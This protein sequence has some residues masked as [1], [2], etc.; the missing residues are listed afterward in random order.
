MKIVADQHIPFLRGVLEP[1]GVV[2]YLPG[3]KIRRRDARDADGLLI[4][5]RTRCDRALLEG[6]AVRFIGSATIGFDH[7][8][9]EYCD[10]HGIQWCHAPGCNAKSV[11]QYVGS[12]LAYLSRKH[13]LEWKSL[14]MGIIGVGNVGS[15]VERLA[16]VLDM[17]VLLNDP[18]RARREGPMAFVS[19][20]TVAREADIITVHTPLDREGPDR[21][22]HLCDEHFFARVKRSPFLIN[23][24]RGEVVDTEALKDA[25]SRKRIRG[26]VIDVWE[27]EPRIDR[28]LLHAADLATPHIAGYSIDGKANGTSMVVRALSG[29]FHLGMDQW[30][31]EGL[32]E[33]G[34]PLVHI[35]PSQTPERMILSCIESTYRVES[36]SDGLKRSPG[37]FEAQRENYPPRR[38]FSSYRVATP[39][40]WEKSGGQLE[41]LG[42][43]REPKP[44]A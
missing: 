19:L 9:T 40:A 34:E 21:T 35:D 17:K 6:T 24:S 11:V 2:D 5:T 22:H 32:P 31:P 38:E 13:G 14:V 7:I 23:T 20:E 41:V 42:F 30:F 10:E 27:N 44:C 8:D 3:A 33:P 28:E 12:A 25:L 26:A 4:R 29:F 18:P 1:F 37:T 16:R 36:D 43:K 15:G 39:Q